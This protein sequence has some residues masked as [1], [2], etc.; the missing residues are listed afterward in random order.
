MKDMTRLAALAVTALFAIASSA[1][2]PPPG[3]AAPAIDP[4]A[5]AAL[6]RMGEHLAAAK[7][8][9][10]ASHSMIDQTLDNGQKV[11]VAR[12]Q[13]VAVR[14]PDGITAVITGDTDD[15]QFWYDGKRVTMLNVRNNAYGVADAPATLDATFDMLAEKYGLVFPLVDLLFA[16]PYKALIEK[17]R[18]GQHLG[19]GYVFDVKCHHLAFRQEGVDWQIWIEEGAKPLP[20]KVVITYKESAGHPQF[21]ALLSDWNL[22]ADVPDSQFTAK[23][24]PDAKKVEFGPAGQKPAADAKPKE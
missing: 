3:A 16:D 6:K 7:R 21:T 17:V 19:S 20:R 1:A 11:Q 10:L 15:L 13:K 14:R 22:S 24:P 8:F 23:P 2:D 18:S 4:K 9:T 5:D 12:N